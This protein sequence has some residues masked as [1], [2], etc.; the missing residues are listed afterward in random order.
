MRSDWPGRTLFLAAAIA[1][2]APM[3]AG[4]TS[5]IVWIDMC[6]ALHPGRKVPLPLDGDDRPVAQGCHAAGGA[7]PNRRDA[8]RNKG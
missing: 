5:R 6:D 4:A 7:L 1:A 8:G 2:G 3:P